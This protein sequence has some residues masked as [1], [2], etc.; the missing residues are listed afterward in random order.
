MLGNLANNVAIKLMA[1]AASERGVSDMMCSIVHLALGM[2]LS[3]WQNFGMAMDSQNQAHIFWFSEPVKPKQTVMVCGHFPK[4]HQFEVVVFRLPDGKPEPLPKVEWSLPEAKGQ[5]VKL[6]LVTE[7]ALAFSL[8]DLGGNGVYGVALRSGGKVMASFRIN[9]PELWWAL[10]DIVTDEMPSGEWQFNNAAAYPSGTLRVFGRCL[11]IG[12]RKPMVCLQSS[13]GR[14]VYL[15]PK[16]A[17]PWSISVIIPPNLL[18][19][20]YQVRVHNGYGGQ[21][22]WSNPLPLAIIPRTNKVMP[23]L[24]VT[25]FGADGDDS[26]DDTAAIKSALKEAEQKGGAIV[27]FPRGRYLLSEPLSI[28]PNIVLRG[29]GRE[30]TALCFLPNPDEP[31]E[32]WIMGL[33]NFSIEDLT[34]FC[35]NHRHVIASDM[36]GDPKRSGHIRL[37]RVRIRANAYRGHLKPEEVDARF[38]ASLKWSTGGGDTVRLSGPDIRI[39]D[40]DLYGSGRSLFLHRAIGVVISNC[41]L[42]NGR[43]GWYNLNCC[44]NVVMERNRIVGADLMSTGGSYACY[45]GGA[46]SRNIYTAQNAY[47]NMH[48]WDREAFTSD[49]GGGAYFGAVAECHGNELLLADEPKW[50][51]RDWRG[52]LVAIYRG[53]GRGQWRT[54]KEWDGKRVRVDRPFDVPPDGTSRITITMLHHRYI[55]YGNEFRDAGVAIQFYG[56]GIEHVVAGNRVWRSGGFWSFGHLYAGGVQPNFYVQLLGN[57]IVEGNSYHFGPN[58]AVTSGPSE[59]TVMAHPQSINF[60]CVVR[61]NHLHNNASI[62]VVGKEAV[63]NVLIEGNTIERTKTGIHIDD[64]CVNVILGQNRFT[65]VRREVYSLA[66][67]RQQWQARLSQLP[68]AQSLVH[69]SFDE[70]DTTRKLILARSPIADANF[71]ASLQGNWQLV[72]GKRGKGLMLDGKTFAIVDTDDARYALNLSSFTITAWIKPE[73]IKGRRGIVAKRIGNVG[74]PFVICIRDGQLTFDAMDDS[75]QW[76][77]N[78]ASPPVLKSNE[79]QHIAVVIEYPHVRLYV[80]GQMVQKHSI[81]RPLCGNNEPLAF[82]RDAWGGEPPS[83]EMPGF[84]IGAIDEVS[85]WHR[86]LSDDEIA[87]LAK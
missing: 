11:Q 71:T 63:E 85:I 60:G 40:C 52:A 8:P 62:R 74:S 66:L 1:N 67:L 48:G 26:S 64:G 14:A 46:V 32:A 44:E 25:K 20:R 81:V 24:N 2:I 21:G 65:D 30:L 4:P 55:F 31:P 61:D 80:N 87:K 7:T 47:E 42:Y 51:N 22:G 6:L 45:Y 53:R 18:T 83:G 84:F 29:E 5:T 78:C 33:H 49:A 70:V 58:N 68:T 50:G 3:V 9:L 56:T 54:V 76:S 41:T 10:G 37:I 72:D 15:S 38:R 23:I 82:G 79:W 28:Q 73:S 75:G 16:D 17:N 12:D 35:G 19:G 77:Y 39:I 36:S 59:I 86:A 43:W 69:W 34:I 57:E 27:F 13:D